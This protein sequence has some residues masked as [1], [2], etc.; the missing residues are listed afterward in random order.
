[1]ARP[2]LYYRRPRPPYSTP[3][4]PNTQNE[5]MASHPAVE[6]S[7]DQLRT[8]LP[9]YE[10][11]PAATGVDLKLI[12]GDDLAVNSRG[13]LELQA[14]SELIESALARRLATPPHGYKRYFIG[15]SGVEVWDAAYGNELYTILSST[16]Y[17]GKEEDIAKLVEKAAAGEPRI[18]DVTV[19]RILPVPNKGSMAITLEY[20]IKSNQELYEMNLELQQEG[21]VNA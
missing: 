17:W 18:D 11:D 21:G 5:A 3:F 8:L 20:R 10:R 2:R 12:P 19:T 1:M 9:G 4:L 7:Q 13:D 6:V 14:G 16:D 15:L